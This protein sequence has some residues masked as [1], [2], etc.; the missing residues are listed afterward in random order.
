[1]HS[2]KRYLLIALSFAICMTVFAAFAPRIAHAVTATLV[3]VVNTASNPVPTQPVP[4]RQAVTFVIQDLEI[5]PG[6]A[7]AHARLQD[8]G[9]GSDYVVPAGK[10]L[11]IDWITVE[12][13]DPPAVFTLSETKF[14]AQVVG[15]P[16]SS[17]LGG[18][19][20]YSQRVL[21]YADPGSELE[22]DCQRSGNQAEFGVCLA[23]IQGHLEDIQ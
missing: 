14:D 10:R 6:F 19:Y 15:L 7:V 9:T 2:A 3:Q 18:G 16:T 23:S 1:M 22:F 4:A 17:G 21:L 12:Q 5:N 13:N 11:V 8:P 20:F